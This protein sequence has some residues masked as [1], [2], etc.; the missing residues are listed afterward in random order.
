[1]KKVFL[2]T[3]CTFPIYVEVGD[4]DNE[5][6][7]EEFFSRYIKELVEENQE[8]RKSPFQKEFEKRFMNP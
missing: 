8:L 6:E 3:F 4:T 2:G 1:M 5:K 7:I